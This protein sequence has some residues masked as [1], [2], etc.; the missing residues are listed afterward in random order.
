M[1]SGS[2]VHSGHRERMREKFFRHGAEVFDT[3]EL[4]EMLL[5]YRIP[6]K[7][8]NPIAHRLLERFGSLEGVF[9]ADV[10]SLCEIDGVGEQ[11][12]QYLRFA[13]QC[14]MDGL[15]FQETAPVFDNYGRV[16]EYFLSVYEQGG[17]PEAV[18]L[19][20]LD[21]RMRKISLVSMGRRPFPEI[22]TAELVEQALLSSA[23]VVMIA[24]AHP[25]GP[26]YV[27]PAEFKANSNLRTAFETAGVAYAEHY[28]ICG[29]SFVGTLTHR[30]AFFRQYQALEDFESSRERVQKHGAICSPVSLASVEEHSL[31]PCDTPHDYL[32]RMLLPATSD[33]RREAVIEA[34]LSRFG[35]V[36]RILETSPSVLATT[37]GVGRS[38]SMYIK[39]LV[40]L[41]ARRHTDAFAFGEVHTAQEMEQYLSF[42]VLGEQVEC[43]YMLMLDERGAAI[44]CE[45]VSEGSVN[46][47][48]ITPRRFLEIAVRQRAKAV[49]LAHNHPGGNA[50]P[51]DEDYHATSLL[52]A[53][54]GTVGIRLLDHYVVAGGR[55]VS[56][57]T[58]S[59][60]RLDER[61]AFSFTREPMHPDEDATAEQTTRD[62]G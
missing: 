42:R 14:G 26:L 30:D 43:I 40:A 4:L 57:S 56:L 52:H 2:N 44:A 54:L 61:Y 51:S 53:T 39:L 38:V 21:N 29:R 60:S 33:A 1:P 18:Y 11:V 59:A 5:Y 28:L 48:G 24:S 19:L 23:A 13:G 20:L 46:S 9:G 7:D 32:Y 50:E 35:M 12:A 37:A 22:P 47:S 25:N 36:R 27:S 41:T 45:R 31:G 62:R 49:L 17:D 15:L 8:T 34:L 6:Y 55:S 10:R 16:G 3:Y 58:L